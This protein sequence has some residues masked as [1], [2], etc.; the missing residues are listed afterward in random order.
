M[1]VFLPKVLFSISGMNY[2]LRRFT[3]VVACTPLE[4]GF[5]SIKEEK[6]CM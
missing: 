3:L 4:F 2:I 1:Y 6:N 5:N